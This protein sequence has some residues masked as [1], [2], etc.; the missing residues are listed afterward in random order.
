MYIRPFAIAEIKLLSKSLVLKDIK[1][2]V[3]AVDSVID[4]DVDQLTIG[5]FYYILMWLRL[6]S[7]PK[8]P[9]MVQ[10]HCDEDIW[11]S[12]EFKPDTTER[13]Y[14]YYGQK[15][16][17]EQIDDYEV[18]KC[19]TEN[20]EAIHQTNVEILSLPEDLVLPE[21]FDFPR[22]R[23]LPMVQEELKNPE[24]EFVAPAAQWIRG[25]WHQKMAKLE[26]DTSLDLFDTATALQETL[27]HGVSENATLTC[28]GCRKKSFY[29]L[30]ID[31]LSFFRQTRKKI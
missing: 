31:A 7:Y 3:K 17:L 12:K 6:H 1:H 22:V 14:L 15:P 18:V 30:Q 10:W 9:I 20:N 5:D 23:E 28:R 21:G 24:M 8:S 4:M 13:D 19:N 26:A 11:R 2:L 27:I 25:D 16:D 29:R